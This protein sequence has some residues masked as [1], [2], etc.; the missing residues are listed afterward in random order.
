MNLKPGTAQ[1]L[2]IVGFIGFNLVSPLFGPLVQD[3]IDGMCRDPNQTFDWVMRVL[4]G[5][6]LLALCIGIKYAPE[7][8]ELSPSQGPPA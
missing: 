2:A 5:L 6:T 1:L 3:S 4:F 7:D 8:Q